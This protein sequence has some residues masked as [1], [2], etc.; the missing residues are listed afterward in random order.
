MDMVGKQTQVEGVA[1][2]VCTS[3]CSQTYCNQ[4]GE[5]KPQAKGQDE[6]WFKCVGLGCAET[7]A[8]GVLQ[9]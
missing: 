6:G 5:S 4:E 2:T 1:H 3:Y 9:Q 8:F 7:A